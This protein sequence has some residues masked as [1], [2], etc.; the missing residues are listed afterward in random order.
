[1][2]VK[3]EGRDVY[4]QTSPKD[5]WYHLRV[6]DERDNTNLPEGEPVD[7]DQCSCGHMLSTHTQD[8]TGCDALVATNPE[9]GHR[10]QWRAC[11]CTVF[12]QLTT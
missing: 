11:P 8:G 2:K 6:A 12:D 4:G 3:R 5:Q 10:E 9:W 7:I 1:M